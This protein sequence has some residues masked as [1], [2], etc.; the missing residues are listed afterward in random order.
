VLIHI[1]DADLR[2][3]EPE[4]VGR[5]P[6]DEVVWV[7][8]DLRGG[9]QG[10]DIFIG[11]KFTSVD[12]RS[13]D[14]LRLVQVAGAGLDGI[15]LEAIP[16]GAAC[17]N[18]YRHE[19]S[20]AEY[21][22]TGTALLR[23]GFLV[24]D[25]ELRRGKWLRPTASNGLP[26]PTG[27]SSAR[28]GFIGFGHIGRTCWQL[29]K[30][31]GASVGYAVSASGSAGRDTDGLAWWGDMARLDELC[32]AS[33]VVVVSLPIEAGTRG[34]VG[35]RQLELLGPKGIL[36]NVGR[37][38]VVEA[39]ALFQALSA[40]TLGG[41]A[42]DVWYQYPTDASPLLPAEQD[43]GS[44][45][46]ILMT[47]HVSGVSLETYNARIGDIIDNIDR[48]RMGEPAINRVK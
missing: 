47:P 14:V 1:R 32:E 39:A 19:Q 2:R 9:L 48:V 6:E 21:V 33:D 40:R 45:D 13:A 36:V 38:P 22:V 31:F 46:N 17:A 3:F 12:A 4:I 26:L 30:S 18:L 15:E 43:F 25:A 42:I 16:P 35:T 27:L 8:P 23:R 10:V 24:Q 20:I 7:D 28:V 34:L 29:F 37:G 41:A 5:L 11:P 44:L